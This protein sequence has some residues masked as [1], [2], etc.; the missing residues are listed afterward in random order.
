MPG[1]GS[2]FPDEVRV[3][4]EHSGKIFPDFWAHFIPGL[5]YVIL[6]TLMMLIALFY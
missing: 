3:K 1:A 2:F 6:S 4:L 5:L